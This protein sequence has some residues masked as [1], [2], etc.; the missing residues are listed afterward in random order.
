MR[1]KD[2]Y[3]K[4]LRFFTEDWTEETLSPPERL[5]FTEIFISYFTKDL[6]GSCALPAGGNFLFLQKVTKNRPRGS[7]LLELRGGV[8][9]W[10]LLMGN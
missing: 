8:L 1:K 10:A 5:I 4:F 6:D 3:T 9:Q 7:G 2:F